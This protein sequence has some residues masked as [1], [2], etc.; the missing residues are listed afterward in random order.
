MSI[1]PPSL[2]AKSKAQFVP[3]VK[4]KQQK[5]T[6]WPLP[7]PLTPPS[8]S[9]PKKGAS[10]AHRRSLNFQSFALLILATKEGTSSR[11]SFPGSQPHHSRTPLS[12]KLQLPRFQTLC[13]GQHI[14]KGVAGAW[15]VG[16]GT[17]KEGWEPLTS[18]CLEGAGFQNTTGQAEMFLAALFMLTN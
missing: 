15:L 5:I 3:R 9:S 18:G 14:Q 17:A 12:A 7:A 1:P 2:G 13:P 4:R 8:H 16:T 10:P 11:L 6:T